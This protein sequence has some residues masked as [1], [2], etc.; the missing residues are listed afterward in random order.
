MFLSNLNKKL[1]VALVVGTLIF[2]GVYLAYL[3]VKYR[4]RKNLVLDGSY[5]GALFK[6]VDSAMN[7]VLGNNSEIDIETVHFAEEDF[8][9][10]PFLALLEISHM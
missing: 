9:I 3:H 1:I 4:Y 5:L 10:R 7:A 6:Q 8:Q 2:C